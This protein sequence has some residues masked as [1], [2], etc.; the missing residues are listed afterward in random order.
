[1]CVTGNLLSDL[2]CL[3]VMYYFWNAHKLFLNQ[4]LNLKNK[5]EFSIIELKYKKITIIF[6]YHNF[7]MKV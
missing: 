7:C 6:N 3:F 5:Y 1:M 4:P 2:F